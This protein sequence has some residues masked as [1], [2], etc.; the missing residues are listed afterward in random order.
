MIHPRP[1][2]WV[3]EEILLDI[4]ITEEDEFLPMLECYL[5]NL[6]FEEEYTC[7]K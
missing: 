4:N 2:V 5:L 7:L 1:E 6:K 3:L